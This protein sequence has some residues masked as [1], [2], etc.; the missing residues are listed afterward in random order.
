MINIKITKKK[1]LSL[2]VLI[3][4]ATAIQT[5]S[6]M[7]GAS[8]DS[9][10]DY[11]AGLRHLQGQVLYRDYNLPYG[12]IGGL[13]FAFFLLIT[14]T[15]GFA[16]I[17]ASVTLN[18]IAVILIWKIIL[19][20]TNSLRY[21]F[22]G[23]VVT[24]FWYQVQMG[25]FFHHHLSY[26]FV[27]G[28]F[29]VSIC[30]LSQRIKIIISPICFTLA[31]HSHQNVGLWGLAAFIIMSALIRGRLFL[32]VKELLSFSGI[33]IIS[34]LAILGSIFLFSDINN[35]FYYTFYLPMKWAS[36]NKHFLHPFVSLFVPYSINP[37]TALFKPHLGQ[38]LFYPIVVVFYIAYLSIFI[39][40]KLLTKQNL[41]IITFLVL[42]TLWCSA[43]VS[44]SFTEVTFAFGGILA[45]T[46]FTWRDKLSYKLEYSIIL[47]YIITGVV[48]LGN[49]RHFFDNSEVKSF[50]STDLFPVKIKQSDFSHINLSAVS[51]V[52]EYLNGKQ[53]NIAVI[54]DNGILIPLALRKAPIDPS[55]VY[56]EGITVPSDTGE[57]EKWQYDFIEKLEQR[58]TLYFV[59]TFPASRRQ[60]RWIFKTGVGQSKTL[61]LLMD[62]I[63]THY[64]LVSNKEGI[65]I[66]KR[67]IK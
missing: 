62:Y 15:G 44:R 21:A 40:R 2:L 19:I 42:S 11:E 25:G 48:F 65:M 46:L 17:L 34:H 16:L 31:F 32:S 38:L 33:Y 4:V 10:M 63:K 36:S 51:D 9:F 58:N 6:T 8:E 43:V 67:I 39:K 26:L 3:L 14:P 60:F 64:S 52:V 47:F 61:P 1:A 53:G 66:Y 59:N 29:L 20:A 5:I 24:A 28:A 12:P 55:L 49:N 57:R 54:D 50:R 30:N 23:G 45:I 35:Y 37:V 22:Y 7:N 18:V 41:L 13:L 56:D 27:L